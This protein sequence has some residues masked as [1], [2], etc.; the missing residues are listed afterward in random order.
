MDV[1]I[2]CT[3]FMVRLSMIT[4]YNLGFGQDYHSLIIRFFMDFLVIISIIHNIDINIF[5][6]FWLKILCNASGI[7]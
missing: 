4:P 5:L 7:T 3:V 6:D 1:D 2:P